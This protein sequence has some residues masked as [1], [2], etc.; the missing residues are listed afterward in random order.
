MAE[1]E[2][3]KTGRKNRLILAELLE[4]RREEA[5]ILYNR[6]IRI[7]PQMTEVYAYRGNSKFNLGRYEEALE[8]YDWAISHEPQNS[9]YYFSRGRAETEPCRH[10]EALGESRQGEAGPGKPVTQGKRL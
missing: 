5:I 8:D 10:E 9:T 6:A 7:D 3:E 1:K 4:N 2:P